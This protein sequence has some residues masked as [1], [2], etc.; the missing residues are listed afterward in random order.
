MKKLAVKFYSQV[1]NPQ[2]IPEVWPAACYEFDD[3][4]HIPAA[5]W[6]VMTYDEL[7]AHKEKYKSEYASWKENNTKDLR[8]QR[9]KEREYPSQEE[10][11]KA[12]LAWAKHCK[13]KDPTLVSSEITEI[14]DKRAQVDEKYS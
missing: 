14:L 13:E 9:A 3:S 4:Q 12:L 10:T 5:E 7:L 8:D 1:E 11:I 6:T 2:L